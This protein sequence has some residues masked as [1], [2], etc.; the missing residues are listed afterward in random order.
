M[1]MLSANHQTEFRDPS[2]GVRVRT[3]GVE[4]VCNPIRRTKNI[5]QPESPKLPETKLPTKEYTWRGGGSMAPG[6]YVAEDCLIW[7]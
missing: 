5:N 7:H 1:W 3:K 2:R 4:G 6:G